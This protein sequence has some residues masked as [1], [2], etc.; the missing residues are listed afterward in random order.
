MQRAYLRLMCRST[1]NAARGAIF[2]RFGDYALLLPNKGAKSRLRG[3]K[4]KKIPIIPLNLDVDLLFRISE[5][6]FETRK[7]CYFPT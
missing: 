6:K 1:Q 2:L 3:I 7:V 4:Q 5:A